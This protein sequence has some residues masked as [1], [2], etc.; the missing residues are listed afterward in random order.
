MASRFIPTKR[1]LLALHTW[2]RFKGRDWGEAR[3]LVLARAL[4]YAT[5]FVGL[6]LVFLPARV[7]S[8][9]GISRPAAIGVLQIGGLV[10]GA[11]GA[12]LALWCVMTFAVVGRGTPAPFDPP[13][14][15]VVQGPYRAVRNPM[16]LGAG[17]ALAAAALFYQSLVLLAYTALFL[18]ATHLFVIGYEE[19]TLR[20]TF[21]RDYEVYCQQV[22]RWWPRRPA[23][24]GSG[25]GPPA[26]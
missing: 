8:W 25:A 1:D 4:T 20:R 13:R 17:L 19:P 5:L 14:R 26:P 3:L 9:S 23:S 12:T 18:L 21:G 10:L 24:R 11:A 16:Y 7:L 6:L 22:R 15:L 2:V